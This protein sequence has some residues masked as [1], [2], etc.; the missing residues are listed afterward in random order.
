MLVDGHAREE[1][2]KWD[3]CHSRKIFVIYGFQ[4]KCHHCL[5][6]FAEAKF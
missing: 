1:M 3:G 4:L 2:L 6:S 5:M